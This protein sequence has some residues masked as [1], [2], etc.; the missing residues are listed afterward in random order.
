MSVNLPEH[1]FSNK[2]PSAF[3]AA[4]GVG[5]LFS[6]FQNFFSCH[7]NG[8]VKIIVDEENTTE[9]VEQQYSSN[10][11]N[12]VEEFGGYGF[13][14]VTSLKQLNYEETEARLDS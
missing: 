8:G 3:Q 11:N 5:N 12:M 14:I 9:H 6:E 2:N 4:N 7:N 13:H 1:S 10:Y